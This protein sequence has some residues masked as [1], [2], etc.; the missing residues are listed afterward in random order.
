MEREIVHL[1]AEVLR[2]KAKP[3]RRV[4]ATVR[5][6]IADLLETMEAHDGLGLAAPQIGVSRRVIVAH[7]GECEPVALVDP[8]I[9]ARRGSET[10]LEGCLS[11]PG[12]QGNVRRARQIT[13]TGL[14]RNGRTVTI[15][16]CD[17]L[18]RV[19]QHE[20]DHLNGVLFIDHTKDIWWLERAGDEEDAEP[21]RVPTTRAEVEA[22]FAAE[23][24]AAECE[25]A[26][27][28]GS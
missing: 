16:A 24:A 5:K 7:D 22:Y 19:L 23:H 8:Q 6:L 11:I 12:L 25:Q 17:L 21:R 10:G 1:G 2:R 3:A 28:A 18:A 26:E 27:A 4:D 13:V 14:D 20:V 15:E 9:R